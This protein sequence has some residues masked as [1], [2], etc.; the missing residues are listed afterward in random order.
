MRLKR[1]VKRECKSRR[2]ETDEARNECREGRQEKVIARI[3]GERATSQRWTKKTLIDSG[4]KAERGQGMNEA[5]SRGREDG[6]IGDWWILG[7][8]LRGQPAD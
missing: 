8:L 2:K 5:P 7:R 4:E 3:L 1:N 6:G